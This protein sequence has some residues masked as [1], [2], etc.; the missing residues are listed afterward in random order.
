MK[1]RTSMRC[2]SCQPWSPRPALAPE[3]RRDGAGFVIT[4]NGSEGCYGGWDLSYPAPKTGWVKVEAQARLRDLPWG[5]DQVHA[6]IVW[7]GEYFSGFAWEPL[8]PTKIKGDSVTFAAHCMKPPKTVGM[9]V[10]LL[11]AWAPKGELVWSEPVVQETR[12]PAPRRWRLGAAGGP[13]PPGKRNFKTNTEAYLALARSGAEQGVDLLCLPEVM[14]SAGMPTNPEALA[15]QAIA[16]PGRH[17][18]PFQELA[19]EA[20]MAL[21][22][23]AWEKNREL[24][25]N[26]AV[27]IGKGGELAGKYRKVHLASPLEEWWG[28]TPGHEFPVYQLGNA[29]VAMNICMDSSAAESARVPARRGAEILCM[30]I[31]GDHR[32]ERHWDGL[33]HDMDM[34]RWVAIQRVRAMDNQI[35]MVISRNG[36]LG[37]GIFGPTG[38]VLAIADEKPL[39]HADVDLSDL[40][41]CFIWGTFRGVAWWERREPAYWPLVGTQVGEE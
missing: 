20:K 21:C 39:V 26:C 23:S 40:P 7:E 5:L 34:D 17:I 24:V 4:S 30:P 36:G 15:A 33:D 22:F 11:M 13:L 29:R 1:A 28:V 35:Y 3:A 10:R 8:L 32:A 16:I 9:R 2:Q 41:R 27:L 6:A 14:L 18:E 19:R 37:S 25:H 31:M 38:D 12:P